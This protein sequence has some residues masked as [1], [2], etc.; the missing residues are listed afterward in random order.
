[1]ISDGSI[2]RTSGTNSMWVKCSI[3]RIEVILKINVTEFSCSWNCSVFT[4]GR[5]PSPT[6]H[7][8]PWIPGMHI[9]LDG[10]QFG[11]QKGEQGPSNVEVYFPHG[12]QVGTSIHTCCCEF[13][14][15]DVNLKWIT[16]CVVADGRNCD[17]KVSFLWSWATWDPKPYSGLRW[18]SK[19]WYHQNYLFLRNGK[20]RRSRHHCQV[21]LSALANKSSLRGTHRSKSEYHP[22]GSRRSR[23]SCE[24][25]SAGHWLIE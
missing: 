21:E 2:L 24:P 11:F 5:Q 1:M 3:K 16:K 10:F 18:I 22:R 9:K 25:K 12:L 6:C 15:A 7:L 23:S 8:C 19:H 20:T 14:S 13:S 17:I 4:S